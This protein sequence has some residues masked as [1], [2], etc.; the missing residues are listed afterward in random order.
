MSFQM[1]SHSTHY[2]RCIKW[3]HVGRRSSNGGLY[4]WAKKEFKQRTAHKMR[5]DRSEVNEL[6]YEIIRERMV[7]VAEEAIRIWDETYAMLNA[8][9]SD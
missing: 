1:N 2:A 8:A 6:E 3:N 9:G 7:K 5:K 4:P